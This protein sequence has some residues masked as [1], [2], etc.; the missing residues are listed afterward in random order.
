M[1]NYILYLVYQDISPF[2]CLLLVKNKHF[3]LFSERKKGKKLYIYKINH[4][5][6]IY[7]QG[8]VLSAQKKSDPL[9]SLIY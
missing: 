1:Q 4:K 5:K 6:L 3:I 9:L 2:F 8:Q 7:L